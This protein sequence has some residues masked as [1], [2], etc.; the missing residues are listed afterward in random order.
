[1]GRPC[2]QTVDYFPH[3]CTHGKTMFILEQLYGND[4]YSFWFKLLEL[5][6]SSE[7]H[8]INCADSTTW[9]FLLSKTRLPATTCLEIL[10]LLAKLEAISPDF[11]AIQVVWCSKFIAN[12]SEA[13]RNRIVEIPKQPDFLRQKVIYEMEV[14]EMRKDI[15]P[16]DDPPKP[17]SSSDSLRLSGL[18]A[19]KIL[20]NNP[21]NRSLQ[22]GMKKATVL[23]WS[24]SIDKLNRIDKQSFEMIEAV[25][26]WSQADTFWKNNI[27]SG[28]ALRKQWDKLTVQ[29]Q[30]TADNGKRP[31]T[32]GVKTDNALFDEIATA[33]AKR[34]MA[35]WAS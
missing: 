34:R 23:K 25:I 8:Y 24:L 18:L 2:K 12:V 27:L 11:W 4:G 21:S 3:Y 5:L 17:L 6:G 29:M 22:N 10:S 20:L 30:T 19:E 35:L 33:E 32:L 9:E 7:G 1:M 28:D 14:D 16:K 13:Y 26:V 31:A 15:V